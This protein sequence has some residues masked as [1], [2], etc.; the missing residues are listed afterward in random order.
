MNEQ[1]AAYWAVTPDGCSKKEVVRVDHIS[2]ADLMPPGA[3]MAIYIRDV[4]AE[5][6]MV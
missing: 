6:R 2:D 5:I 1:T 3:Y 4:R